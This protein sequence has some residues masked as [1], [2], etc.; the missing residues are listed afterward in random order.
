MFGAK[1]RQTFLNNVLVV[2]LGRKV[3]KTPFQRKYGLEATQR[4]REFSNN[5]NNSL[6]ANTY[7]TVRVVIHLNCVRE[8]QTVEERGDDRR[9]LSFLRTLHDLDDFVIG[10]RQFLHA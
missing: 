6:R 10:N 7:L 2:V 8:A 3:A 9:L 1:R 5:R 4:D